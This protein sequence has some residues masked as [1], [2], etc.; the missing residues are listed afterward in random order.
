MKSLLQTTDE[1]MRKRLRVKTRFEKL[2]SL[3]IQKQKA[4]EYANTRKGYWRIS[5][6]PILSKALGNN[7]LKGL[8]FLF[9][10]DYYRQMTA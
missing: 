1:W 10:S 2:Q 7:I 3:G 5:N 4:W 9:F 6:S 8:G